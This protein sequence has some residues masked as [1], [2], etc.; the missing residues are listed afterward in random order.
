MAR[1]LLRHLSFWVMSKDEVSLAA[2]PGIARPA[3]LRPVQP[4][5]TSEIFIA[6]AVVG[7]ISILLSAGIL[8]GRMQQRRRARGRDKAGSVKPRTGSRGT[9]VRQGNLRLVKRR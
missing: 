7:A 9:P 4:M 1:T 2:F 5:R 8:L 3:H 6:L